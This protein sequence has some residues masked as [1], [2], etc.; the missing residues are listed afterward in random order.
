[1]LREG[2]RTAHIA[3]NGTTSEAIPLRGRQVVGIRTPSVIEGT[4]ITFTASE[5]FDGTY[6]AVYDSDGSQVSVAVAASRFCGLSGAEADA[7]SAAPFLKLVSNAA[8]GE[9]TAIEIVV[10]LK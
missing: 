9:N 5:K 8:G 1:M 7:V 3:Q 6:A 2:I 4:A 10:V